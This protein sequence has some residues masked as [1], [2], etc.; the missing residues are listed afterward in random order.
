MIHYSLF[1][2]NSI[3]EIAEALMMEEKIYMM[4]CTSAF[5]LFDKSNDNF[6]DFKEL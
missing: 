1:S 4:Y 5:K 2:Q 3:P 6:I